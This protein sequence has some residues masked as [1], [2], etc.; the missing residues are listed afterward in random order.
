MHFLAIT[1]AHVSSM[2]DPAW[3]RSA[4]VVLV[5]VRPIDGLKEVLT[6]S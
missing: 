2:G 6:I 3:E 5:N 4:S 1:G